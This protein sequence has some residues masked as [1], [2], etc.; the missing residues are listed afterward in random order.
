MNLILKPLSFL[1][2]SSK[3]L[4]PD[5]PWAR[6][7]ATLNINEWFKYF[8]VRGNPVDLVAGNEYTIEIKPTLHSASLDIRSVDP[9]K[10]KCKFETEGVSAF[11]G[12]KLELITC[13]HIAISRR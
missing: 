4:E 13:E 9:A 10:R 5:Q 3:A 1:Y 12:S 2:R 11:L 6:A 8:N 7:A